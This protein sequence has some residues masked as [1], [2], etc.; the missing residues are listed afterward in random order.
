MSMEYTPDQDKQARDEGNWANTSTLRL[1]KAPTGA[2]N[3]NVEGRHALSPLQGFGQLWQKTFRVRLNGIS[4]GPVEVIK[5]WKADFPTFWP[6]W[7]HYYLPVAGIRPGEVAL[8]NF[9]IPGDSAVGLPLST[10]VQVI[11]ADDE[12]FTFTTPEGHMFAGW[13]TFSAY[14]D[15]DG[16]TVA[17]IR[18]QVRAND[19]AYEMGF[20][21]GATR[22][23]NKMWQDALIAVAAH[24]GVTGTVETEIICLDPRVQWSQFWNIWQ[25]AAIRTFLY[26]VLTP[27][28]LIVRKK[29]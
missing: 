7:Q 11:Y 17:Q 5:E 4:A 14:T 23:E 2:L 19:F 28:R 10:A 22:T 15:D 18:L 1:G 20:R 24:F 6:K 8:L 29:H 21:M 26:R 9:V 25:N 3:L 12:S 13:N 16:C 27:F